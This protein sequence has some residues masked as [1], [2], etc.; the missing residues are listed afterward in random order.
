MSLFLFL[1]LAILFPNALAQVATP[2]FTDC[3]SGNVSLKLN[4]S[5]VYAQITTSQSLGRQLNITVLGQSP[6]V[7]QG[8]ANGS[9]DLGAS[10]LSTLSSSVSS[11]FF[12][13]PVL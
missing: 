3:F 9:S 6:Q 2:R 1:F 8:T 11:F 4:V 10:H 13:H 7:I 5:S 12:S